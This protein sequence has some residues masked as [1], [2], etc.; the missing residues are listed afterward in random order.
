MSLKKIK[1]L[2]IIINALI[3]IIWIMIFASIFFDVNHLI[4]SSVNRINSTFIEMV[5]TLE[6][7]TD[8][9]NSSVEPIE[10]LS[11]TLSQVSQKIDN[12]PEE[13][14]IPEIKIPD[15][16]L[17]LKPKVK[18]KNTS[19]P[20]ARIEINDIKIDMPT[21]P[22]F[23][24]SLVSIDDLKTFLKTDIKI[25]EAL[26]QVVGII[27]NLEAVKEYGQKII[28][29]TGEIGN[30]IQSIADKFIFLF[31]ILTSLGIIAIPFLIGKYLNRLRDQITQGWL[32]LK[33]K[34]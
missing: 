31:I 27:P 20:R 34:E 26:K 23:T 22:G 13:I 1:G 8:S 29:G 19:I 12:I 10:N 11:V 30:L 5:A 28:Y 18:I 15:A 9:L 21:I 32:L 25:L 24:I 4:N 33:N 16:N 2:W 7:A 6:Q 3:P 14:K 17:P